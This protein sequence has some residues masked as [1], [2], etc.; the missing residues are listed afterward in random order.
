MSVMDSTRPVPSEAES[1]VIDRFALLEWLLPNCEPDRVALLYPQGDNGLSPGWAMG[2][3]NATRAI[4]AYRNGTLAEETFRSKTKRGKPYRITGAVRLGLVPHRNKRVQIFCVDLDDHGD[5][6]TVPLAAAINRFFGPE[7]LTFS[8]KGG[9]GLHCFFRLAE[10]MND[11]AFVQWAKA[12]GFNRQGEPEVF[13]KTTKNTQAWLPNEPNEHGGDRYISGD[14]DSCRVTALPDAPPVKLTTRTLHFLR[15]FVRA[16]GRNDALNRAAFELGQKRVSPKDAW[17][18]CERGAK[19]CGLE[20]EEPAQTVTTFQSGFDAGSNAPTASPHAPSQHVASNGTAPEPVIKF[21]SLDGVGNGE[22]FVDNYGP[23][24]RY[25]Y[26]LDQ[27][28]IWTGKRWSFDSQ[29]HVEAMAKKTARLILK[30]MEK[31]IQKARDEGKD[32]DEIEGIEKAYRRQ[33]QSAARVH[34]VKDTLKMAQS[35]PGVKVPIAQLDANPMLM[36]VRNGTIDLTSGQMCPH[37]R[38]DRITKLAPVSFNLDAY[39]TRWQQFLDRIFDGDEEL[40]AYI[41]RAVG[42]SLT[43]RVDE[44][45]LFFLYG[46]GQNGKSV[47]IQTLLHVLGE[48]AQKAPTEMI[49]KQDR[50]SPGNASPDMAR[51]RGVRMAVTA[52]L[53]ENQRM[54]EARVKDLT[55]ADRI[56]ARPL[57]RNPIEFDPTHKLWIYGNHKPT[58]RGTDDGIWRRIRL[59]PFTVRIPDD[60]KDPHLTEKLQRE[61]D[62]ILAWAV[63][64]CLEWQ[65]DGLGLPHAVASATE[66]YRSESDRLAEFLEECCVQEMCARVGKSELYAAYEAWCRDSGEYAMSK[67]KLG[68]RLAER[69]FEEQRTKHQREWLGLRLIEGGQFHA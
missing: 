56:V 6:A 64:G 52:E 15:G 37:R 61:R 5:G 23:Q 21:R 27:W 3:E 59:I 57:Y 43:G 12:W 46:S 24:V 16:P 19:L 29:A 53:E 38:G 1:S 40:I 58:I 30:E 51:L 13:P 48:Y 35:E 49:M 28:L 39:S 14:F 8:S 10:P 55:G 50:A 17:R 60:E 36:N 45:C 9:K 47:F 34:G 2:R 68:L 26:D 18:L 54:G 7:P 66:A 42:Y 22:R 62:G 33:Y 4:E 11:E 41:Q 32:D 31:A 67:K 65:R 25:S 20:Q 69:G 63:R 44:Q